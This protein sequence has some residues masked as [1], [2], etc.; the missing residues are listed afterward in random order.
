MRKNIPVLFQRVNS[1]VRALTAARGFAAS[2]VALALTSLHPADAVAQL[3]VGANGSAAYRQ[4]I[5]VPPGVAGLAPQLALQYSESTGNGIL[6]MGWRLD[7]VSTIGRCP[8]TVAT[9]GTPA[10]VQYA[11]DDKLCLDGRRLIQINPSNWT[12]LTGGGTNDAAGI[13]G[14][15]Y[16]EYRTEIDTYVRVRAYGQAFG[17]TTGASGPAYFRVWTKSGLVMDYGAS[18]SG[19]SSNALIS[20]EGRNVAMVWA[21]A[22]ISDVVGNHVDFKYEQRDVPW[23]S[24]L[25]TAGPTLGRDWNLLEIQYSGNKVVLNYGGVDSR[26]DKAEAYHQGAKAVSARLLQ[27]IT[28]YVNSPNTGTLGPANPGAV[29][30]ATYRFDYGTGKS[31]R[32]RL[33]TLHVCAGDA[34]STRC[35]SPTSFEYTPGAGDVYT[36]AGGFNLQGTQMSSTTGTMGVLLGDFDGD[37]KTDIL[38]WSDTPS[39]N[40]LFRSNGDGSF[41]P[42]PAGTGAGQFNITDQ[43]LFR[44]D[45]CYQS[46][47]AD[48]D[49]DGRADILR[50]ATSTSPSLDLSP[51]G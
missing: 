13:A 20:V 15:G 51:V 36:V 22:Q 32:Y 4:P 2:L 33:S 46:M 18:P 30:V 40:Q 27:S 37:G 38:R 43:N 9:D 50:Y 7:G 8:Q 23:G 39:Q 11:A 42:V 17:D 5:A 47:V 44:S 12:P 1:G 14:S 31:G 45:G 25:T 24:A 49:G 48:F 3:E 26:T 10:S 41:K 16:R 19:G 21:V 29:P 6:G 35:Q 28:T 34:S